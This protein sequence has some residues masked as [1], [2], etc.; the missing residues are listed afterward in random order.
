ME[1][2][3]TSGASMHY[4][5][6]LVSTYFSKRSS[7]CFI[8]NISGIRHKMYP[9][10]RGYHCYQG[11]EKSADIISR[12]RKRSEEIERTKCSVKV[13]FDLITDA[14]SDLLNFGSKVIA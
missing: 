2:D 7:A 5:H 9:H 8:F 1:N 12:Y 14:M 3:S 11:N 4:G 13:N 6:I 10:G